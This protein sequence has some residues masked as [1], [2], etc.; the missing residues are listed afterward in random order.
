VT[1]ENFGKGYIVLDL[2]L[3]YDFS[4]SLYEYGYTTNVRKLVGL[5]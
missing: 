2:R 1:T 4:R 5:P 3:G